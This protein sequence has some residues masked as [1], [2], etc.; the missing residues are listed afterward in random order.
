MDGGAF[1]VGYRVTD[2]GGLN[3][4]FAH[5]AILQILRAYAKQI[6]F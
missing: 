2:D 1:A 5:N 6:S 3:G 4:V